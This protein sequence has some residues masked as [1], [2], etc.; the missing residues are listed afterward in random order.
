LLEIGNWLAVNGEAVFSTRPWR[1]FG[2]GPTQ[3]LKG[4]FTD[5]KRAAF[6]SQ[7]I[8]FTTS[9]GALYATVLAWPENGEVTIQSLGTNLRLYPKEIG[10]V[11]LLGSSQ[12][13]KWARG[14]AGL[15]VKFPEQQ[16]CEAA[17]VVKVTPKG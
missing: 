17:Y 1:V 10:N 11:Q 15:K 3:V 6:T 2:E 7:D 14:K 12:P 9:G 5:T 4:G 16:P 13:L 8:R